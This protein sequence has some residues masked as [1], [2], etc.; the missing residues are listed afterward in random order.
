MSER[1]WQRPAGLRFTGPRVAAVLAV[2]GTA[3]LAGCGG[4]TGGGSG[5]GT[6]SGSSSAGMAAANMPSSYSLGQ[7]RGALLTTVNGARP[8]AAPQSGSYGS[9][10]DIQASKQ[11]MHGVTV[12]PAKCADATVTGFNS[13]RFAQSAA[14]VV[15]FSVGRDGVS[16]VIVAA[17]PANAAAALAAELPSGCA[18]YDATVN[19]KTFVYSIKQAPLSGIAEQARA[20]NVKA[21]GYATVN[22]WSV[23]YRSSGFVGAVTIVGPDASE[24][25][26]KVLAEDAYAK[27]SESLH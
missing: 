6:A 3:A 12:K 10:P 27:A 20:L 8:V 26:A 18:H 7:L 21:A 4:G 24:S 19:G 17:S 2:A 14:S 13:A 25:G 15:T 16:E 22:A 9:L 5:G 11:L 1:Y 23:V